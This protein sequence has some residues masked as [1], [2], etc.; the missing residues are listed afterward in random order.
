[1]HRT[2]KRP[3]SIRLGLVIAIASCGYDA[4]P[5][6]SPQAQPQ[7]TKTSHAPRCT[8]PIAGLDAR[9]KTG[10]IL[11]FG[12]VHG[13]EES[14]RFVGD[15]AC[16]A[17]A[18]G[19]VQ[20]GL[21]IPEDEQPRIDRYLRSAGSAEDRAALLDGPF[22][23]H[24]D[25]RSSTGMVALLEQLRGLR[26]AGARIDVV[27]FDIASSAERATAMVDRDTAMAEQVA[28]KR[29]PAAV[30]VGLSGN[31]HSRRTKGT[32]WNPELVPMVAQLVV[33]GLP[34]TTFDV[35]SNGGSFWACIATGPSDPPQC[36][37]HQ[38]SRH[39][40]GDPWTLG[41]AVD[42]SHDGT[43]RVGAVTAA[44]PALPD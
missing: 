6:L 28:R 13:T 22:W 33:R 5:P 20:V 12:E 21:E 7:V 15:V 1:E 16:Q 43:Y 27:P 23:H 41:P 26:T 42:D 17:A 29:D 40:P 10:A 32:R 37:T 25:G 18:A 31:V 35:S 3:L 36:G 19:R 8:R 9:I 44:A 39:E 14:P 34:I 24:H 38:S 11:W 30:F 4:K 2:M